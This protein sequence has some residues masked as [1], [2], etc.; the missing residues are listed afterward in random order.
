MVAAVSAVAPMRSPLR[1]VS[2]A[3]CRSRALGGRLRYAISLPPGYGTSRA[4]DWLRLA[5]A[6]LAPAR[7]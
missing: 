3:S 7:P 4:R 6:H 1:P 5:L 2:E